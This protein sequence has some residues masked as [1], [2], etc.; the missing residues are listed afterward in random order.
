MKAAGYDGVEMALPLEA[1]ES[2]IITDT[3]QQYGLDSFVTAGHFR[4]LRGNR[5]KNMI[6]FVVSMGFLLASLLA[7]AQPGREVTEVAI[8]RISSHRAGRF[9]SILTDF[10]SQVSRLNGFIDYRTFQDKNRPSQYI[11]LLHWRTLEQATAASDQVKNS[12]RFRPFT[13]S[14]D[15]LIVYG[16]FYPFSFLNHN[17]SANK[18]ANKI[19]EVVVYQLKIDKVDG[20]AAIAEVTNT[21]LKTQPGFITRRIVQDHSNHAPGVLCVRSRQAEAHPY[22]TKFSVSASSYHPKCCIAKY[23]TI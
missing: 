3:L 6:R 16:E 2:R 5:H 15:S 4:C 13:E 1:E 23:R 18:M 9:L 14:I 21:F 11:D 22:L 20:Y 17:Q 7:T 12:P 10:R 19:T 8:Y